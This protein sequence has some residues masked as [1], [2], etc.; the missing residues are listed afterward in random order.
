MGNYIIEES[1]REEYGLVDNG[2][3]EYNLSKVPFTQEPSF[4]PINRVKK[5]IS[6]LIR[7]PPALYKPN[8]PPYFTKSFDMIKII[9][10]KTYNYSLPSVIDDEND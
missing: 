4:I 8:T 9:E 10:N 7:L 3:V 6:L 1:T 2:I 5:N